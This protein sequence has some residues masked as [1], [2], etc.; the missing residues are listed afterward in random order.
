M[1]LSRTGAVLIFT[2]AAWLFTG[3]AAYAAGRV[4]GSSPVY[5]YEVR[6]D[7][8]VYFGNADEVIAAVRE[9]LSRHDW[10]ITVSFRAGSECMD[11]IPDIIREVMDYARAETASPSEGDYLRTTMGGYELG[12]S[13]TIAD[14]TPGQTVYA[15]KAVITPDY[16]TTP[17]QEEQVDDEV[18]RI[19]TELDITED[20][21][22]HERFMAVYRYICENVRYDRVHRSH[23]GFHLKS[24]AFGA[25]IYRRATCQGYAAAMYR[26]LRECGVGARVITGT[27]FYPDGEEY[28]AWNIVRID[29]KWYN[30][31]VMW[32][33]QDSTEDYL[34]RSDEDFLYHERSP[35]FSTPEF[36]AEYPM[37]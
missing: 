24:T 32:D 15:Y 11:D 17:E 19:I 7:L 34:L 20:M 22:E 36:Y 31:D 23:S 10:R 27:A 8:G 2:A 26:L 30:T 4:S 14:D 37:A 13:H 1:R 5:H 18:K 33:I 28:H 6:R 35:E 16:Y 9:S 25:L 3:T 29:G 21:G 12:Y